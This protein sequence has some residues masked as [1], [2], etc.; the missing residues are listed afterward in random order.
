[1][2]TQTEANTVEVIAS[3]DTVLKVGSKQSYMILLK[4]LFELDHSLK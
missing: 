1:M 4:S 3:C 2:K